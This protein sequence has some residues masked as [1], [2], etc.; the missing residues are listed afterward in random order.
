MN[1]HI[2]SALGSLDAAPAAMTAAERERA[3]V[4]LDRIV[5]TP[6]SAGDSATAAVVPRRRISRRLV[7]IPAAAAVLAIGSI[8]IPGLGRDGEAFANWSATPTSVSAHDLDAVTA[9]CG[10]H[11]RRFVDDP[12]FPLDADAATLAL[13]E[14]RG[15]YVALLYRWDNPDVSI[16][17]LARNP[18]GSTDVDDLHMAAGGS[19]GPALKA[20]AG[21]FTEGAISEFGGTAKGSITD[22]AV[23]AGVVGVTIHAGDVTVEATVENGRYVAWWPGSAFEDTTPPSGEGGPEVIL[24]YDLTL[25]DGTTI[26][27]A[28]PTYPS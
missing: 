18:A 25:T 20:P 6:P 24:T 23:G 1:V 21:G 13:A 10:E 4:V 14:R 27:D 8:V 22:G 28:E 26:V 17:C 15:D 12:T 7:L 9:V 16:P 5:A 3:V 11:L 2:D 19:D